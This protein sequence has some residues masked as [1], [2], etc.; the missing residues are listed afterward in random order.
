MRWL[1]ALFVLAVPMA[2]AVA[3]EPGDV[4]FSLFRDEAAAV[5]VLT[6]D[7]EAAYASGFWGSAGNYANNGRSWEFFF[8]DL[9]G[10]F[11][12]D[13]AGTIAVE[14]HV[15]GSA[16]EAGTAMLAWELIVDGSV[17]ASGEAKRITYTQDKAT[18]TWS[19]TAPDVVIEDGDAF[20]VFTTGHIGKGARMDLDLSSV[21]LPV[22]EGTPPPSVDA[23]TAYENVT[24][25]LLERALSDATGTTVLNWTLEADSGT[26]ELAWDLTGGSLGVKVVAPGN[27]TLFDQPV[28]GTGSAIVS[29][30]AAAGLWQVTLNAH[31]ATGNVTLGATPASPGDPD[32]GNEHGDG[33]ETEDPLDDDPAQKDSPLPLALALAGLAVA[34]RRR[35]K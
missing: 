26:L 29:E 25:S 3:V 15:G 35:L 22:L 20:K 32:T 23:Q 28:N 10:P 24:G 11:R 4:E 13:P 34:A 1:V 9:D 7:A 14:T 17:A 5:Y 16:Q 8:V 21:T 27:Q 12:L 19:V 31:N 2:S 6:P 30:M 33:N 18:T